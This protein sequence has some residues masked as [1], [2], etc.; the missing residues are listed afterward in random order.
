MYHTRLVITIILADATCV[1]FPGPGDKHIY[2]FNPMREFIHN[3]EGH[4]DEAFHN[5]KKTHKKTY[6]S[7][8]DHKYR[9]NIFRQN[10]R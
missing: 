9:K 4:L 7:D 3:Y 8:L 1:S 6:D 2:T 5:F 10:M